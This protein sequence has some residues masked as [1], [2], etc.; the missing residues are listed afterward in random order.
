MKFT[1]LV[2]VLC[3]SLASAARGAPWERP[4]AGPILRP[5]ELSGDRYARG[6]HRGIDLGAPQGTA[7]RAACGGHV[8]FAGTVPG[9]GRTVS[10]ACGALIATY[11]HLGAVAV[12]RG[13]ALVAGAAIGSVGRS[14]RPPGGRPHL[15][16]GARE[17]ANGRYVDP[18]ELFGAQPRGV[19]PLGVAPRRPP[20]L[21]P[22]PSP[23]QRPAAPRPAPVRVP[24]RSVVDPGSAGIAR[25]PV[26]VWIGL[27]LFGLGLP[28]GGLL[29][30]RRRRH[31]V[32]TGGART[33][34]WAAA[35]R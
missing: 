11:Q 20:P 18:I 9:G 1:A 25:L 22:A 6:Q 27:A 21:G 29:T 16:L 33:R 34:R 13:R 3:L 5:F 14:G 24:L 32:V 23:V 17:A 35:H 8:R 15:H 12:D 4:V 30:Q 31:R 10:V 7:V 28:L 19:P 26:V 2:L